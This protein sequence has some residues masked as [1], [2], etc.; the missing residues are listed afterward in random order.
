[1]L[2][3]G[4]DLDS[5]L[6][7]RLHRG[8]YC[9][10]EELCLG[11]NT[12][13][14]LGVTRKMISMLQANGVTPIFVIDGDDLPAKEGENA[15][16]KKS[17]W[18]C[19][20]ISRNRQNHLEEGKRLYA[21]GRRAEA[22]DH[23]R[24]GVVV[25]TEMIKRFL[26]LLNSL[27][28]AYIIA[29][30]EADSELA[31]LCRSGYVDAVVSEDSDTLCY[32][33][34]HVLFKMDTDG[35]CDEVSLESVF[36]SPTLGF[37]S[38]TCDQFELMCVLSGCDYLKS[39]PQIGLKTAKRYVD[40]GR[41]AISTLNEITKNPKHKPK[42]DPSGFQTYRAKL[43]EALA[44]FHHQVIFDPKSNTMK[45]LTPVTPLAKKKYCENDQCIFGVIKKPEEAKQIA[46]GY[47][48]ART[49]EPYLAS[50]VDT[51]YLDRF[52]ESL[53]LTRVIPKYAIAIDINQPLFADARKVPI[54]PPTLSSTSPQKEQSPIQ[55]KNADSF[56]SQFRF[57][58][59]IAVK[60]PGGQ[61]LEMSSKLKEEASPT[62]RFFETESPTPE[63]K[64]PYFSFDVS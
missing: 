9:C 35:S 10:S 24:Q 39:L 15:D 28:I 11:R 41:Y 51:S 40:R 5:L 19:P 33:C 64:N 6:I 22:V 50:S 4:M 63:Y 46:R 43:D 27:R 31:Y 8:T 21:L 57:S 53:R 14:Y 25:T 54:T 1:M 32:R 47:Q 17:E 48:C 26:L 30:Y 38:W 16:R 36:T 7:R 56:L 59:A 60:R 18:N 45:Y 55:I 34:H 62:S 52:F 2:C 29:P 61:L 13:K 37:E 49:G 44:C 23:F 3:A 12:D 42:D 20:L 58:S